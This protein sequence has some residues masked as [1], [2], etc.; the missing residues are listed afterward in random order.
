MP[1]TENG[2]ISADGL[3]ITFPLRDDV[4]W[5]DGEPFT[6]ADVKFTWQTIMTE[7]TDVTGRTGWDKIVDVETPDEHTAVLKFSEIDAPFLARLSLVGMLPEHILGGKTAEE[8]NKDPW[9]R[10]PVGTGPFMFKEWVPGDHVTLV[11]NPNY[12]EEG[13]PYLDT[14]IWKIVPDSNSLVNQVQTGDVDVA[15]RVSDT[16]AV[17]V[18][19]FDNVGLVSSSTVSPWLIW[20]QNE[21]PGLNDKAVR[22]A[23]SYAVDRKGIAE[24]LL[25]GLLQPAEGWLPADSWA[26]NPEAAQLPYDIDKANQ[27]LDEAGW[28]KGA[29]GIREKDGVRLSF[30]IANIAGQQQRIQ[31]LTQVIADWRKIGVDAQIDLVDVGTLFGNMLPNHKFEMG[32]SYSGLTADPDMSLMFY[33]PQN[34]PGANYGNYCNPQV[35]E[36]LKTQ[37]GTFD[38]AKRKQALSEAQ[39]LIAEDVP[40]L[41]LGWRADHTA[42]NSQVKGYLPNPGYIGAVERGRLAC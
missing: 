23:L 19:G 14:L 40:Y 29:D 17:T 16:D 18:K 8:I 6:S 9:F 32:Y 42:V 30:K 34:N 3:T 12:F 28:V 31:V 4:T 35:D 22:Q 37:L 11:K 13:K 20:L 25:N 10:V 15:L 5:Q 7:G 41:Y 38:L 26:Y 2:N 33:C 1:T 36:L 39:A 21:I 27:I 24:H